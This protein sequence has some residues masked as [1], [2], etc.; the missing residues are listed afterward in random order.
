MK[1]SLCVFVLIFCFS[2]CKKD[3]EVV[4]TVHPP[5]AGDYVGS[6]EDLGPPG[7][8]KFPMSLR[9]NDDYTGQ[10]FYA[11]GAFHPFGSGTEDAKVVLKIDG[12]VITSFEL[13]QAIKGYKGGC[14]VSK[15]LTGNVENEIELVF[16]KFLWVD[17][18][19]AREVLLRFKKKV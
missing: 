3:E 2:S 1:Q 12:S 5:F 10:M 16:D 19:G 4:P 14:A 11:N 18:D 13:N 15:I 17:C 6:W 7:P 8:A 9:I